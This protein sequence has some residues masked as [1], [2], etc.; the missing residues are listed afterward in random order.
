MPVTPRWS[1]VIPTYRRLEPLTGALT[2]C[3]A[4]EPPPGGFEVVVV[5]DGGGQVPPRSLWER[6]EPSPPVRVVAQE[7]GGPA[8]ARNFGADLARGRFLAFLD[9]DCRPRAE[10]LV[11]LDRA[12]RGRG[13]VMVGGHTANG[14]A[15]ELF[16][17]ASQDLVDALYRGANRGS[18]GPRFFTS[19]NIALDRAAF[20]ELGGFDT[21]Y[22][23]AGG[24]DRDFCRRW[25]EA[26]G[27]LVAVER[28]VVDHFHAMGLGGFLRQHY[29][30]GRGARRFY[31]SGD[32]EDLRGRG[33]RAALGLA[34]AIV[35]Q[36]L[37][38]PVA[39]RRF[40]RAMALIA[41]QVATAAG[42]LRG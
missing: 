34:T 12:L 19:N 7:N 41:A 2:A 6:P 5:D 40:S 10:W 4:L 21:R 30:Y 20:L 36:P 17:A 18:G 9:D 38:S 23:L 15:G 25:L 24:E 3:L 22:P 8:S 29:R 27:Q 37:R 39:G 14:L 1:V 13:D 31:A 33:P 11:E 28:A 42:R 16:A 26:G 35:A 32:G